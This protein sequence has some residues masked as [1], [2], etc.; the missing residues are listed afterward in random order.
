[1]EK[2]LAKKPKYLIRRGLLYQGL[3]ELTPVLIE[4]YNDCLRSM[5]IEPTARKSIFVDG[6]GW[7]PQIASDMKDPYYLCCGSLLSPGAI[8]VTPDQYKKPV[9]YPAFSWMRGA[10]RLVFEK[11]HREI[12]DITATH[13]VSF[14]CENGLSVLESPDDLLLLSAVTMKPNTGHI[15]EAATEQ[16]SLIARF[17]EGLNCLETAVRD[18]LVAHRKRFG[19][20][21][22]RKL[23][24]QPIVFDLFNDFYTVALGGAAVVRGVDGVDL[25]VLEDARQFESIKGK[26]LG[27]TA[28]VCLLDDADGSAFH[29]L[30]KAGIIEIPIQRFRAEPKIL[31]EKKDLLLSLSLCDCEEDVGWM[32]CT[33][34]K[35]KSL[36]K[37][38]AGKVPHLFSELER[39]A[40]AVRRNGE[41][42][43]LTDELWYFLAVPSARLPPS[44]QEVITILL[45]RKEPRNILDLYICDK[46]RFYARYGEWSEAKQK[47]AAM[48]IHARY[49]PRMNQ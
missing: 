26:D 35:R 39:Y 25:L 17:S 49:V 48:Y 21:R 36:V 40:A 33:S 28:K 16:I 13:A 18:E 9:Y 43:K 4:R 6:A 1:M 29:L 46:N 7:S 23:D 45:T 12:I 41:T 34:A 30:A 38:H 44:T 32:E 27:N 24:I 8:I 22:K 2:A 31:E 47:W 11:Y 19:D 37:K 14:D 20:L 15:A 10:M 3:V 5:G 42:P